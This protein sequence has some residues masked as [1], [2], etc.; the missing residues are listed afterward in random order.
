MNIKRISA[1]A[2]AAVMAFGMTSCSFGSGDKLA[3]NGRKLYGEEKYSEAMESFAEAEETGLK[4]FSAAELYYYMGNCCIKLGDYEKAMDYQL[5][6]LEESD[7]EYFGA[8]VSLGVA[9]RKTGSRERALECYE[10]ALKIDPMTADSV[11]LYVSL[12]AVYIEMRKPISA[13]SYLEKARELSPNQPDVYAYL[14]VAYKMA[15]EPK[16]SEEAY[17]KARE[18]GYPKMS[19]IDGLLA[20]LGK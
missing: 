13:V 14:A 1:F 7:Y 8:W 11:P 9:Y 20:E 10:T 5:K 3:K 6:S 4:N 18:L 12:G 17:A 19:E 16:K 15:I 2:A